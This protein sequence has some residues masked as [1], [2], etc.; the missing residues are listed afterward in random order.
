MVQSRWMPKT[1]EVALLPALPEDWKSGSVEG[2]RLRG[3]STLSMHWADGKIVSLRL[4]ATQDGSI[5]LMLPQHA[6]IQSVH[7]LAGKRQDVAAN[8]GFK[9]KANTSY[10]MSLQ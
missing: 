1:V 3:G 5:R 9:L 10:E 2:L 6:S 7:T 4:H 8:G